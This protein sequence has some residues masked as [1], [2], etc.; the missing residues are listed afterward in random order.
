MTLAWVGRRLQWFDRQHTWTL[1]HTI[2]RPVRV[3]AVTYYQAIAAPA[4]Q[5]A[6]MQRQLEALPLATPQ[7]AVSTTGEEAPPAPPMPAMRLVPPVGDIAV[8]PAVR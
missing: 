1:G 5:P 4:P 7:R 8:L 6:T 2:A 3:P